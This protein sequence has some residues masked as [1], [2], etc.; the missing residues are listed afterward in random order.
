MWVIPHNLGQPVPTV[1]QDKALQS[2]LV[3][4]Q[5]DR[6]REVP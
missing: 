2:Q 1:W 4:Q 6:V 3:V 5:G